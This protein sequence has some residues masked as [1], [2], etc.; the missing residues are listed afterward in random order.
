M[1]HHDTFTPFI[2]GIGGTARPNSTSERAVVEALRSAERLGARTQLFGGDF[3]CSLP[4]Y[5]PELS[6]PLPQIQ[7]FIEAIR[8]CD[9]VI[10]ATPGY[11]GSISG[12]IK[13]ILDM[14]EQTRDDERPYLD[15]RSFACIVTAHGWQA[16]GTALVSLR[17]IS[18]ALRAWPTPLGVALNA[19]APL[20]AADG[21]CI[22]AKNR[23]QLAK[24]A[25]Q[26][27]EFA[28]WRAAGLAR[29]VAASGS[30]ASPDSRRNIVCKQQ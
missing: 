2:V 14:L 3:V 7:T 12:P 10:V 4:L 16:C 19:S 13:N 1:I 8:R 22:D 28:R 11:H 18:H 27:V 20:F 17:T 5:L 30:A 26:V 15:G 25:G 23:E 9:G 6:E 24:V 29:L 21:T